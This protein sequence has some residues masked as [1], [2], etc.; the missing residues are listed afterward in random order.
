VLALRERVLVELDPGCD[1]MTLAEVAIHTTAG[2]V[3][4]QHHDSGMP[5][6]DLAAQQARLEAKF[7]CLAQPLIGDAASDALLNMIARLDELPDLSPLAGLLTA[8]PS[9]ASR[10]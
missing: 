1:D 8:L 3:L 9:A 4:R 7:R 5:A 10:A 2:A 6:T